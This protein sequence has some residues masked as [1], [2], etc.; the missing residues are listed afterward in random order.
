MHLARKAAGDFKNP[1][2]LPLKNVYDL[3][4]TTAEVKM[5]H[6][7]EVGVPARFRLLSYNGLPCGPTIRVR[8]GTTLRIR[9]KND[10]KGGEAG[11]GDV[12]KVAPQNGKA[13]QPVGLDATNLHTHGLHVSPADPGDN[14]LL[15]RGPQES[16]DFVFEIPRDLPAGTFWYHPH[17]HGSV[18]YQLSNGVAGALI[19]EGGP[20]DGIHDLEDIPEVAAAKEEIFLLALYN[21]RAR[22]DPKGQDPGGVV[23][24]DAVGW[25]DATTIYNVE[26]ARSRVADIAVPAEDE[27]PDPT[28]PTNTVSFQAT[29]I[30]GQINPTITMAPGEVRRWRLIHAGWDLDRKL[31][32]VDDDDGPTDDFGLYEVAVDGLATG[33]LRKTLYV[34]IAP[35]Q[36]SDVLIQAPTLPPGVRERVYHLKQDAVDGP[37][38]PHGTPQDPLYLAR[39]VVT[40]PPRPMALP[41]PGEVA[42]CR[43][44]PDVRRAEV[45]NHRDFTF[46]ASDGDFAANPKVPPYYTI[47]DAVFHKQGAIRLTLNTAEEWT[48]KAENL[49]HPFHIHVNP[50][51]VVRRIDAAGRVREMDVWRD[52]LYIKEGETY[53]IRTRFLDHA[54]LSVFHC[55]ILDHEDQGMMMPL[56]FVDPN[57]SPPKQEICKDL[58]AP[59]TR[60]KEVVGPAPPLRLPDLRGIWAAKSGIARR[61]VT[62]TCRRPASG[63]T[64][65]NRLAVPCRV[66]S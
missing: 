62:V 54:G 13:E 60:L 48:L 27:D 11:P 52:T 38:A 25:I 41:D 6:G 1:E 47:N 33:R 3:R 2:E 55:H 21:F 19:V 14:I 16:K 32:I 39:I 44:L 40:G 17:K 59:A 31:L 20:N 57:G 26:V 65:T 37:S 36:R 42:R 18:A 8:R 51:Q 24:P 28:N 5:T 56:E 46:A 23:G 10:L 61:S 53:V 64:M 34:E 7:A 30:N 45:S 4:L 50:F 66:Y 49:S 63:S 43:P 35:G 12:G 29:A 22:R 9:L 15:C 58:Q